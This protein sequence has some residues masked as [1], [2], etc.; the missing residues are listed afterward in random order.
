MI[1]HPTIHM[2]A[3]QISIPIAYG[4][5]QSSN[6]PYAWKGVVYWYVDLQCTT[7]AHM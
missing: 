1:E 7:V 4:N 2:I 3:K 5:I 6:A